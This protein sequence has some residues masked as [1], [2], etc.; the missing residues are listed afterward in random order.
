MCSTDSIF[1][2][3]IVLAECRPDFAVH[4]EKQMKPSLLNEVLCLTASVWLAT[5][6]EVNS[7]PSQLVMVYVRVS[8]RAR[9]RVRIR[10]R[11]VMQRPSASLV[12]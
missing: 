9:V 6:P 12:K 3:Y 11:F 4:M 7:L 1:G 8:I 5:R 2:T 10:V